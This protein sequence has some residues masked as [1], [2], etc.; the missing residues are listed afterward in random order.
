MQQCSIHFKII[1]N[2][3]FNED[4]QECSKFIFLRSC[5]NKCARKLAHV[6]PSSQCKADLKKFNEDG[7][8]HHKEEKGNSAEDFQ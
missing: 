1:P 3:M 2:P 5:N 6:K 7:H 8:R 4:L